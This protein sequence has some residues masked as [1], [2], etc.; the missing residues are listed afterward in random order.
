MVTTIWWCITLL[1]AGEIRSLK[2]YHIPITVSTPATLFFKI[3]IGVMN[4]PHTP[5]GEKGDF[6]YIVVARDDLSGAYE[7][8]AL[9]NAT[10]NELAEF[11]KDQILYKYGMVLHIVTDP[12]IKKTFAK[13]VKYMDLYHIKISGYNHQANGVIKKEHFTM[14]EALIKSCEG[15]LNIWSEKLQKVIFADWITTSSVTEYSLYYLLFGQNPILSFDIIYV[16]FIIDE[17]KERLS[18]SDLLTLRVCQL[19]KQP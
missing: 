9:W 13:L 18:I 7:T 6:R 12:E 4:M 19:K 2:K 15:N 5:G 11:F 17:F 10:A 14:R 8:R 1:A 3:Y 16:T